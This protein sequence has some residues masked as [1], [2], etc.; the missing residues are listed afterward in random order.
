SVASGPAWLNLRTN[1]HAVSAANGERIAAM[2]RAALESMA[3]DPDGDARAALLPDTERELLL[4]GWATN[5][6]EPVRSSVIAEFEE[7]AARTPAAVAVA[8]D[9]AHG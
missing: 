7:Q 6:A 4:G 1:S 3:A 5:P 8:A 9:G 2:L